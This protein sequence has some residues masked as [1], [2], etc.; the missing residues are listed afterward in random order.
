MWDHSDV[1][2][3]V[4]VAMPGWIRRGGAALT[5]GEPPLSGTPAWARPTRFVAGR[6]QVAAPPLFGRRNSRNDTRT[7]RTPFHTA[8]AIPVRRGHPSRRSS[9]RMERAR[10]RRSP[11][12]SI[13]PG[14]SCEAAAGVGGG[15]DSRGHAGEEGEGGEL[16]GIFAR[17]S[18]RS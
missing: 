11:R 7:R 1:T 13:C 18:L 10:R 16:R 17:M 2:V 14:W 15:G 5:G 12:A 3:D 8:A 6:Q 9:A 4:T